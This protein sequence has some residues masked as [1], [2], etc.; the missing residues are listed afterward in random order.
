MTVCG[1]RILLIR[2]RKRLNSGSKA[3]VALEDT[4]VNRK[5]SGNRLRTPSNSFPFQNFPHVIGK[6]LWEPL[7]CRAIIHRKL[8][9]KKRKL[10]LWKCWPC[11]TAAAAAAAILAVPRPLLSVG[12]RGASA[13][14]PAAAAVGGSGAGVHHPPTSRHSHWPKGEFLILIGL[15]SGFAQKKVTRIRPEFGTHFGIIRPYLC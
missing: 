6:D 14:N 9:K 12:L 2:N 4:F 15:G 10:V 13:S 8:Q 3:N 5:N 7:T 11:G 1:C